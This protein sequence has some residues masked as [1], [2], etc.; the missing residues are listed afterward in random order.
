MNILLC[1]TDKSLVYY[2]LDDV[3]SS[4]LKTQKPGQPVGSG[5]V[6][7]RLSKHREVG[8]FSVGRM[9]DR[10]LLFYKR[11]EGLS[12]TFNILEP[13]KEKGS[14][15]KRSK[16]PF[17]R[18]SDAGST[19]YF[20][21]VDKIYVPTECYGMNIFKNY[22]AIH[23]S[24]GFEAMSLDFKFARSLPESYVSASGNSLSISGYTSDS[25]KKKVDG[26]KPM[27]I[28]RVMEASFLLCYEEF[29]IYTD[30]YGNI[31]GSNVINF[32]SKAS[33]VAIQHPYLF[34]IHE[35]MIEIRKVDD[36]VGS[37]KQIITGKDIRLMD[38]KED[39]LVIALTHPKINDR[40]LILEFIRNEYIL[41][42]NGSS[43]L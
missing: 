21:D 32:I 29:A 4:G 37:V 3:L 14:L 42:D 28:F 41:E 10:T 11:K 25:L 13:V 17:T 19:E 23:S 39:Q 15:K 1:I 5:V 7:H 31:M 34:V 24:R 33:W 27:G 12:S 35:E 30:K 18:V 38:D 8:F 40:Q 9:K 20:R 43:D 2:N 6:G 36:L 26:S 22:F 16:I